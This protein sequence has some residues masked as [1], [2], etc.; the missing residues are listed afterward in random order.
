M[1]NPNIGLENDDEQDPPLPRP[2]TPKSSSRNPTSVAQSSSSSPSQST[3][4][5]LAFVNSTLE[6]FKQQLKSTES[7]PKQKRVRATPEQL[8]AL[9]DHFQKNPSP[10]A[11]AR[12]RLAAMLGMPGRVVQVW[13]QNRRAKIKNQI[14]SVGRAGV[15]LE[16][17]SSTNTGITGPIMTGGTGGGNSPPSSERNSPESPAIILSPYQRGSSTGAN[18][19]GSI[20]TSTSSVFTDVG[21]SS[22]V[23]SMNVAAG[24]LQITGNSIDVGLDSAVDIN[25]LNRDGY[26][27]DGFN[28]GGGPGRTAYHSVT[29]IRKQRSLPEL[30]INP[31]NPYYQQQSWDSYAPP[32]P[33]PPIPEQYSNS[34]RSALK[35]QQLDTQSPKNSIQQQ[36]QQLAGMYGSSN[37]AFD[38]MFQQQQQQQQL[39][40]SVVV[41]QPK[42]LY[43]SSPSSSQLQQQPG[44]P[45]RGV[46]STSPTSSSPLRNAPTMTLDHPRYATEPRTGPP[47]TKSLPALRD[48]YMSYES[49]GSPRSLF[50]LPPVPAIPNRYLPRADT[51]L[52]IDPHPSFSLLSQSQQQQQQQQQQGYG[53]GSIRSS[54]D[55]MRS[56]MGDSG[57]IQLRT[58]KPNDNRMGFFG[59]NTNSGASSNSSSTSINSSSSGLPMPTNPLAMP[60]E[61][62]YNSN[63]IALLPSLPPFVV[64]RPSAIPFPS[65]GRYHTAPGSMTSYGLHPPSSS[66]MYPDNA[67]MSSSNQPNN[68]NMVV[69]NPLPP[70]NM[71]N[72]GSGGGAAGGGITLPHP[73]ST[74]LL[75][76]LNQ[77]LFQTQQL[78]QQQFQQQQIQQQQQSQQ[79]L[80]Q[81][82]AR[83][84]GGMQPAVNVRDFIGFGTDTSQQLYQQQQQLRNAQQ[85][86]QRMPLNPMYATTAPPVSQQQDEM[87]HTSQQQRMYSSM[88]D[89]AP[90]AS[91]T[92]YGSN[93]GIAIPPNSMQQQDNI[94]TYSTMQPGAESGFGGGSGSGTYRS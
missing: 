50:D 23:A 6:S 29:G 25:D 34:R 22:G 36:Q 38:I 17:G 14:K 1:S 84:V 61:P 7:K 12:E 88:L 73:S 83:Q 67:G 2:N 53:G 28:S 52:D 58:G 90:T 51:K 43:T 60:N 91:A 72:M 9:Q 62:R 37:D 82:D 49:S 94:L 16:D 78:Q 10:D 48:T 65:H 11:T 42:P 56:E 20:R 13:F 63:N 27:N 3:S 68:S 31:G 80:Q 70:V 35:L 41:G 30:V 21:Y 46:L 86:L 64:T 75:D 4:P 45:M 87:M 55:L 89:Y 69:G 59:S 32:P 39:H 15:F 19:T 54:V 85:G 92:P 5:T 77:R 47:R 33:L 57:G 26:Y 76:S 71:V 24:K 66:M 81:V 93:S 74:T 8:A 79:Q 40:Q 18:T 44:S